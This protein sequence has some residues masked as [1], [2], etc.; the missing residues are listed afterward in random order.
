MFNQTNMPCFGEDG[1]NLT[2]SFAIILSLLLS[3]IVLPSLYGIIWYERFG[4]DSKRTLINQLFASVC[5]YI[6]ITVLFLQFPMTA[7]FIYTKPFSQYVC[8]VIDFSSATLYDFALGKINIIKLS[9]LII[10][11]KLSFDMCFCSQ[12]V[13]D[14]FRNSV[15]LDVSFPE[16]VAIKIRT[17]RSSINFVFT[18]T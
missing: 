13:E 15:N 9:N 18:H 16:H 14:C 17:N 3:L 11:S 1:H 8:T 10:R 6:I 12:L 2:K 7:R 5:W 4:S